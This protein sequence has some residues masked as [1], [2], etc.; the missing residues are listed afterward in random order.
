[1]L[2]SIEAIYEDGVFKPLKKINLKEHERVEIKIVPKDEWHKRFNHLIK[3]IH[4]K[5][6]QYTS[7]E[8]ENDIIQAIKETRENKRVC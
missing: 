3:E 7:Q 5:A 1:M 8:I 4:K 6:S 2:K